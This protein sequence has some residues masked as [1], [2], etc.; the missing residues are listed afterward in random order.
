MTFHI[1]TPDSLK[2]P[3][4]VVNSFTHFIQRQANRI[5]VGHLCYGEPNRR[6]KYMTRLGKEFAAYKKSGNQEHLFNIANY[7]F[8]EYLKPEHKKSHHDPTIKSVTRKET[9]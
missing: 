9:K 7:A 1:F 2:L 6:K 4:T 8:L 5:A 3:V